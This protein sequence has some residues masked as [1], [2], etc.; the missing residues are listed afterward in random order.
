MRLVDDADAEERPGDGDLGLLG[1]RDELVPGLGMEDAVAGQ[2]DRA[3]G[4]RDLRGRELELTRV[5]VHVRPEAGQAG[6]DLG[7]GRM[8]RPGL[9]LQR[10]LG[11]VDVDRAR[12]TGPGDVERLGDDARQVIGVADQ[13]VVLGHRQRDA[14][15]VDLLEC[16]L[17]DERAR[18]ITGDRDDGHGVQEGGADAGDEVGRA[19]SGGAHAHA[20]PSGDP[21]VAVG[22]VSAALLVADEHVTQ[23]RVVA[24]DVVQRQDHAARIREEDIDSLAQERL[25][26]DVGADARALEL[27]ALVE[28]AF[29]GALDRRRLRRAVVGHVAAPGR[30]TRGRAR[31]RPWRLRR[32][33]LGDRHRDGSSVVLENERPS[34][35]RRGS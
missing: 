34:P 23:L 2:D 14:V 21:C 25:A 13:V 4:C 1:E 11:D 35:P 22:G 16:V 8:R 17:A 29:A 9:L 5:A 31:R 3:L 18:D 26:Q 33:S 27:A 15:D 19:G 24:E 30:R 32:I 7:L 28:H 10:V 6:D 12:P 20:D